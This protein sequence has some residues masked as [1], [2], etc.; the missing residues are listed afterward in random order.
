MNNAGVFSLGDVEIAGEMDAVVQ[1]PVRSLDGMTAVTLEASFSYGTG[2]VACAAVV[3][4]TFDGNAWRDVAR[5]DF[6]TATAVKHCNLEGLLSKPVTSYAPLVKQGFYDGVL[7]NGLRAV[8][9]SKGEYSGTS[10]A[11]R[12]SV[13]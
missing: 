10:L 3:Q 13:R 8:V 4:T 7:G 1:K 11:L 6:D 12:A 2:G 9:S 5:F